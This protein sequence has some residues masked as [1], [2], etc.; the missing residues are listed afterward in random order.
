LWVGGATA[1]FAVFAVHELLPQYA[2]RFSMR[3][4]VQ[5]QSWRIPPQESAIYCYPHRF[6]SVS[7]YARQNEVR[8]FSRGERQALIDALTERPRTL[9]VVQTKYLDEVLNALP[10]NVEVLNHQQEPNVT[11]VEIRRRREAPMWFVAKSEPEA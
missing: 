10:P 7:F 3:H 2:Q 1:A 11:I 4:P 5:M 6:D 8:G 9:L